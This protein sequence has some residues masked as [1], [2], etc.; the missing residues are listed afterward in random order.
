MIR[1]KKYFLRF[2]RAPLITIHGYEMIF[3]NKT[4]K[5][6]DSKISKLIQTAKTELKISK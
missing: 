4:M 2:E 6:F 1:S 3:V 5:N